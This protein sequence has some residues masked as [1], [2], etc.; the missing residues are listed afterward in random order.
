MYLLYIKYYLV[1]MDKS[2]RQNN[3]ALQ[4]QEHLSQ[5]DMKLV[6]VGV[7]YYCTL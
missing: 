7:A 2:A 3:Q 5:T 6:L 4:Q 1:C